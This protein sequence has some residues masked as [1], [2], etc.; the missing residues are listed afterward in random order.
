MNP[1]LGIFYHAFGIAADKPITQAAVRQGTPE[2]FSNSPAFIYIKL[3][4]FTTNLIYCFGLA[5][6]VLS[7]IIIGTG[8]YIQQLE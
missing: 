1:L 3:G 8:N 4:G 6:L 2:L 5:I 7:T